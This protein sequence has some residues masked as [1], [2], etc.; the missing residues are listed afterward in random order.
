MQLQALP[1]NGNFGP[2]GHIVRLRV[3]KAW[4]WDPEHAVHQILEAMIPAL[5]IQ[6]R[7]K[8]ATQLNVP[9]IFYNNSYGSSLLV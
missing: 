8:N 3:E 6:L 2:H 9:V 5:E 1:Q 4:E 7:P